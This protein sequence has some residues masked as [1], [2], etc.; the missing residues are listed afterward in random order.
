MIL[1]GVAETEIARLRLNQKY[2]YAR[3]K[4]DYGGYRSPQALKELVEDRVYVALRAATNKFQ[5]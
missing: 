2:D 4:Y 5:F 3:N 1:E